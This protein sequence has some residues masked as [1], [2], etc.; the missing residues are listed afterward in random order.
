MFRL[1]VS[2]YHVSFLVG[3]V[4]LFFGHLFLHCQPVYFFVYIRI[5]AYIP[6]EPKDTIYSRL[7]PS[8]FLLGFVF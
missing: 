6:K 3:V 1:D 5:S 7:A 2:V 8:Q 4:S